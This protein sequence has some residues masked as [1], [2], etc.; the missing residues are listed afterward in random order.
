[1]RAFSS[2]ALSQALSRI[3][4]EV[5]TRSTGGPYSHASPRRP[6]RILR[7]LAA[8]LPKWTAAL[9][10]VLVFAPTA[11][12][13]SGGCGRE[14]VEDW[15]DNGRI[16][17]TYRVECYRDA[18]A[19]LPEDMQAYSSAPDDI[20]LALQAALRGDAAQ[21]AGGSPVARGDG[22]GDE[23]GNAGSGAGGG[24]KGSSGGSGGGDAPSDVGSVTGDEEPSEGA[25][26]TALEDIGPND[27]SS[28]PIPL[29]ILGGLAALTLLLGVAGILGR[30]LQARRARSRR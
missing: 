15:F 7:H 10:A 4:K 12:A 29:L 16:D 26:Q 20:R 19:S 22:T 9:A 18:L 27:P 6:S 24:D 23:S 3:S 8:Y 25:F 30:R 14:V 11:A 17:G 28:F 5:L 21:A 13:Q 1:L 2:R